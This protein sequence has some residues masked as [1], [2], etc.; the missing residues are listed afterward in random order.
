MAPDNREHQEELYYFRRDIGFTEKIAWLSWC[1]FDLFASLILRGYRRE[2]HRSWRLPSWGAGLRAFANDIPR[3][4][5]LRERFTVKWRWN[6]NIWNITEHNDKQW[7]ATWSWHIMCLNICHMYYTCTTMWQLDCGC[8]Q[9]EICSSTLVEVLPPRRARW[10]R[11]C[12]KDWS[13]REET[14]ERSNRLL[15]LVPF[16]PILSYFVMCCPKVSRPSKMFR[17]C[18]IFSDVL[19]D[20]HRAGAAGQVVRHA[21]SSIL[22]YI[23]L[24]VVFNGNSM[25]FTGEFVCVVKNSGPQV[26]WEASYEEVA[27]TDRRR[28]ALCGLVDCTQVAKVSHVSRLSK[29]NIKKKHIHSLH[30]AA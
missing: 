11:G 19:Q 2:G 8:E 3:I 17:Y 18:L 5:P 25:V 13:K 23:T 15:R 6:K 1:Q 21:G 22:R 10:C 28:S 4:G 24:H 29:R 9:Q 20:P 12:H 30:S 14:T 7:H 27:S 16:C 26:P